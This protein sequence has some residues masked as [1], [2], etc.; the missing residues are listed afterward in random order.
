ML[1]HRL[2]FIDLVTRL[3]AGKGAAEDLARGEL[4]DRLAHSSPA[5]GDDSMEFATA[6]L[7][8]KRPGGFRR[9]SWIALAM[10]LGIGALA[11][12]IF[13]SGYEE[14]IRLGRGQS[15]YRNYSIGA[16]EAWEQRLAQRVDPSKKIFLLSGTRGVE[17]LE[18]NRWSSDRFEKLPEDPAEFEELWVGSLKPGTKVP[19]A[20]LAHGKRIDPQNGLWALFAAEANVWSSPGGRGRRLPPGAPFTPPPWYG[21]SLA[22][23]EEALAA[24]RIETYR[25]GR[26]AERLRLLGPSRDLADLADLSVFSQCQFAWTGNSGNVMEIWSARAEE[27]ASLKDA[28][29]FRKWA[30]TWDRVVLDSL[31]PSVDRGKGYHSIYFIERSVREFLTLAISLKAGDVEARMRKWQSEIHS[32][33]SSPAPPAAADLNLRMATFAGDWHY[34]GSG[35]AMGELVSLEEL[36]PGVKT[37]HS[38]ADRFAAVAGAAIFA[39][40]ALVAFFEGWRRSP[41]LRGMAQGLMPLLRPIDYLWVS[42]LGIALPLLWYVGWIR[43]TPLGYRDFTVGLEGFLPFGARIVAILAFSLCLLLQAARWRTAKR[44]GFVGLRP[45]ALWPGWVVA[46]IAAAFLPVTGL[47]R[48]WPNL[49]EIYY[50]CPCAVLGFPLLWLLWRGAS[51]LFGPASAALAGVML[52]RFLLPVLVLASFTLMS[53]M[54]LLKAEERRWMARDTISG[55]DPSGWVYTKLQAR[56]EDHIRQRLLKGME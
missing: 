32:L 22:L 8:K 25:P 13:A 37:E 6:R 53:L 39:L 1:E 38:V 56:A 43:F 54:P 46:G 14:M 55:P 51:I 11:A 2:R 9:S 12:L 49:D 31:R 19:D 34:Y 20:F 5:E 26:T 42:G 36:E 48:Y 3:L 23:L 16:Q 4:M 29:G 35:S 52:C 45:A 10:V 30:A 18:V 41:H 40:L 27:L 47:V 50:L 24:P 44:G 7:E 28:E 33:R 21:K 17:D 15:P